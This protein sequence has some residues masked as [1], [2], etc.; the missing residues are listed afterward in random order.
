MLLIILY[1]KIVA[2]EASG[3]KGVLGPTQ[4]YLA[5]QPPDPS[6]QKTDTSTAQ[7]VTKANEPTPQTA[8]SIQNNL[9]SNSPTQIKTESVIA[10][11]KF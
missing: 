5:V 7:T 1:L 9:I 2:Q 8:N 6:A 11:F 3:T 10:I 4:I